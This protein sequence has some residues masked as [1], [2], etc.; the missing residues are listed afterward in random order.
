MEIY[1]FQTSLGCLATAGTLEEI[2][3]RVRTYVGQLGFEFFIYVL[4]LPTRFAEARVIMINGYPE[5]WLERY[6]EASHYTHDPVIAH[7]SQ[8]LVPVIWHELPSEGLSRQVMNEATEFGL[9]YG[10]SMPIH[11]PNG[12]LG[13]LSLA[14]DRKL[15]VAQEISRRALP[16]VQILAGHIHEAVRRVTI[17]VGET[18]PILLTEREQDCMRWVADGKTSWEI[19]QVLNMS[20]RTVNFHINN[21][22][23]KLDVRN[24]QH[25]IAR[26]VLQGLINPRPF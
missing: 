6:W 17:K 3:D 13:I 5:T 24:R 4:R 14:V 11:G 2:T 1:E 10:L 18:A 7:C 12:D 15:A 19:S 25:A 20:E 23:I 9:R 26:A 8:R 21:V 22:M 16:Y